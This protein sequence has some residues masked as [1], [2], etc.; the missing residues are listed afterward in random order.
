MA[1]GASLHSSWRLGP[2]ATGPAA[3]AWRTVALR[4]HPPGLRER[5][6]MAS[7]L[8]NYSDIWRLGYV[9]EPAALSVGT[10]AAKHPIS[11]NTLFFAQCGF[12]PT[13]S[14]AMSGCENKPKQV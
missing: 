10:Y 14:H 3:S 11:R 12:K 9:S 4:P 8:I 1:N 7:A 6:N 2:E 5:L 13:P